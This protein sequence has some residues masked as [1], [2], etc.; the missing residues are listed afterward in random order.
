MRCGKKTGVGRR[1]QLWLFQK[2][3][4]AMMRSVAVAEDAPGLMQVVFRR[5]LLS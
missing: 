5:W 1:K 4:M 3:R 2:S